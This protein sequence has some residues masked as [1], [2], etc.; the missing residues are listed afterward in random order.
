MT[1]K[2]DV[3]QKIGA[4]L[5]ALNSINVSGRNNVNNLAGSMN[6]LEEL[7]KQLAQCEISD[8]EDE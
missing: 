3:L 1:I 2:D 4:V 7:A 8:T 5:G 6:I